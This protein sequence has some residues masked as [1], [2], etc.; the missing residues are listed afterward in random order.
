MTGQREVG[1]YENCINV[2]TGEPDL[3]QII[4][5]EEKKADAEN[6]ADDNKKETINYNFS[7]YL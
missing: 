6:S 7:S 1:F 5:R 4:H 3:N 2:S